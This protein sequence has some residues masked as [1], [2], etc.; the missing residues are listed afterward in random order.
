MS[1]ICVVLQL[2]TGEI[3]FR[4][5]EKISFTGESLCFQERWVLMRTHMVMLN[6]L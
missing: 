2:G 3:S 1:D 5:I 4:F 6:N